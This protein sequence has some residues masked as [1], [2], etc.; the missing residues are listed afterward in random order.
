[1]IAP[2]IPQLGHLVV[3]AHGGKLLL[4]PL[5]VE[6]GSWQLTAVSPGEAPLALDPRD[7]EASG[8]FGVGVA[9]EHH[10]RRRQQWQQTLPKG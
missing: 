10:L 5:E 6:G 8:L 3:V 1:M 2:S 9:V 4:R 7:L